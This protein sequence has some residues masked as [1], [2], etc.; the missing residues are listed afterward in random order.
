MCFSGADRDLSGAPKFA[1]VHIPKTGGISF[2]QTLCDLFEDCNH[3]ILNNLATCE[4]FAALSSLEKL[5]FDVVGGHMTYGFDPE[6]PRRFSYVTML[7]EPVDRLISHYTGLKY[8]Q[9]NV[10]VARDIRARDLSLL[11][12]ARESD[13]RYFPWQ[14]AELYFLGAS[15]APVGSLEALADHAARN[16]L[17]NFAFFGIVERHNQ[18]MALFEHCFGGET[19]VKPMNVTP[20]STKL[21]VSEAERAALTEILDLEVRLYDTA[22][23][24][25]ELRLREVPDLDARSAA[26][27][28]RRE[29]P[30]F[31]M[32]VHPK[33]E[34]S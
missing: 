34:N 32:Q 1:Y 4:R 29:L 21:S 7:R 19:R 15:A 17:G 18:S 31:A 10:D 25:F 11:D 22:V 24:A 30:T 28:F 14:H 26:I 6:L 33:K 27:G 20:G 3:R 2:F 16:L 8:L 12:F 5:A 23:R 13:P 9:N